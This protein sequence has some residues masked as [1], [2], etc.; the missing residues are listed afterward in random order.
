MPRTALLALARQSLR[1]RQPIT[2]IFHSRLH[3]RP[4]SMSSS[5]QYSSSS[6][7]KDEESAAAAPQK[8]QQ[9]LPAPGEGT[10]ITLDVSGEGSTVKLSDLGPLVVN[11]DGTVAPHQQLEGD[12][13]GGA[14][15][16]GAHGRAAQQA[17]PRRAQEEEGG[18]GR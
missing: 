6:S 10:P 13:G 11:V 18:A 9:G 15:D 12:D 14:R 16:D 7:P 5:T 17:A 4:F 2:P 3:R 8:Q 1:H